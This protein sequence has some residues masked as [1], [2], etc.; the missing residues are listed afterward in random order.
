MLVCD[1]ISTKQFAPFPCKMKSQLKC[2][3][4]GVWKGKVRKIGGK[5]GGKDKVIWPGSEPVLVTGLGKRD[6]T[7]AKIIT[8]ILL[9]V[10]ITWK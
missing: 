1:S 9:Q 2:H 4:G 7:R 6:A 10:P 5:I 3:Q 8:I